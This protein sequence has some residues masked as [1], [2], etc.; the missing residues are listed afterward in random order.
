[1]KQWVLI[2]TFAS[3]SLV[4]EEIDFAKGAKVVGG[5]AAMGSG[6][7]TVGLGDYMRKKTGLREPIDFG[8]TLSFYAVGGT[9]LVGGA[10]LLVREIFG[11]GDACASESASLY[12]RQLS[13]AHALLRGEP[14][15]DDPVF[16]DLAHR[17]VSEGEG[18]RGHLVQTAHALALIDGLVA[19]H[20]VE[21]GEEAYFQVEGFQ[22]SLDGAIR[23]ENRELALQWAGVSLMARLPPPLYGE[24]S[25]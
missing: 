11:C 23:P 17:W 1:M 19:E 6:L 13:F 25:P 4:A 3:H 14:A 21:R 8:I 5:L 18:D 20:V 9:F 15:P 10:T 2:L 7:Y 16:L 12:R 22:H 24:P